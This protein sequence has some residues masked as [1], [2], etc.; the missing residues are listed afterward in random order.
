MITNRPKKNFPHSAAD[1]CIFFCLCVGLQGSA[2]SVGNRYLTRVKKHYFTFHYF[3][4]FLV[5][6]F[7]WELGWTG[8]RSNFFFFWFNQGHCREGVPLSSRCVRHLQGKT[9]LGGHANPASLFE[10]EFWSSFS[11]SGAKHCAAPAEL[12]RCLLATHY[13]LCSFFFRTFYLQESRLF[14]SEKEKMWYVWL[15][16]ALALGLVVLLLLTRR[17]DDHS[18][19]HK[20]PLEDSGWE[21]T[22]LNGM[23]VATDAAPTLELRRDTA[24]PG[25]RVSGSTGCNRYFG[26]VHFPLNA[27]SA[28]IQPLKFSRLG[29]TRRACAPPRMQLETEFLNALENVTAYERQQ[30]SMVLY[31]DKEQPLIALAGLSATTGTAP[32]EDSAAS[33]AQASGVQV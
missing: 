22:E 15:L 12:L 21:V 6:D 27:S 33:G 31:D 19:R 26:T 23:Q 16:S 5:V 10:Q 25:L 17:P 1:A 32:V 8:C 7:L 2:A 20:H 13:P 4:F 24:E 14:G 9:V 30:G 18:T 11:L 3:T 29:S 28:P